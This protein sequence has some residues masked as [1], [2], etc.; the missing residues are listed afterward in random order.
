MLACCAPGVLTIE[1]STWFQSTTGRPDSG[2]FARASAPAAR[3][4]AV[5]RAARKPSPKCFF[6]PDIS[7][8]PFTTGDESGC[9]S[10]RSTPALRLTEDVDG[11]SALSLSSR[12]QPMSFAGEATV[13][14]AASSR[15]PSSRRYQRTDRDY[16]R[17]RGRLVPRRGGVMTDPNLEL[18]F[19]FAA[20]QVGYWLG[21]ASIA[22]VLTGLALDVTARHRWLLVG[23]TL[24]AAACNTA[25]MLIPWRKWL[26]TRRG[27]LLLDLW[28]GGLIAFV[29]LL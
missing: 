8:S 7:C 17:D 3:I 5:L 2:W 12:A 13:A 20:A 23:A 11:R 18:G 25:A 24:V 21:W 4:A 9:R 15:T 29:A 26:G 14:S 1:R 10:R 19:R 22:V 6:S 16:E 28:C 27:L